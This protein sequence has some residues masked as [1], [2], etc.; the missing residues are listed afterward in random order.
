MRITSCDAL[1]YYF[2]ESYYSNSSPLAFQTCR[3]LTEYVEKKHKMT[4]RQL[5]SVVLKFDKALDKIY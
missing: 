2:S 3:R 1:L 5:K 4:W